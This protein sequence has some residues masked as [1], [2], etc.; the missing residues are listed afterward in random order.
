MERI[1]CAAIWYIDLDIPTIKYRPV[2][3]T[4]GIVVKGHRHPDIIETVVNFTGKRTCS[5][6]TDCT[7]EFWQGF[8]TNKNRFVTREKA[9]EIAITARQLTKNPES[10]KLYSEDLY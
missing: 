9:M 3:I 2:N 10:T 8:V 1:I 5:N 6:G 4:Q 7:G